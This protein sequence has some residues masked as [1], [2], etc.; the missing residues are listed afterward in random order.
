[1]FGNSPFDSE[2]RKLIT[3]PE[4]AKI[5]FVSDMF[6]EDYVG[7]A[8]LT[9]EALIEASPFE[10]F[11]LHARDVD[12][13]LLEEA[14]NC[15]WIFGNFASLNMELIPTICANIRYS[16]L[17]YDYKFCKYRSPEKHYALENSDCDC[18]DQINGKMISAF[19]YGAKSLWWMSE[20]QMERYHEYFPF[21]SEVNNVVLSSVF[22]DKFFLA[23]KLLKKKNKD[24][25]R[26]GWVV[27]GSASW[28]KGADDAK[29]WCEDNNKDYQ[30]L[31][32]TPY[33]YV[34]ETLAK[35]EGF[36][37]L[38]KG[39]DT[40]P[41]MVIE[42]KLLGCKLHINDFVEHKDEIWFD[43]SDE[44]D[45]EAYLYA[46][47]DRFWGGIKSDMEWCPTLSGY[48]TTLDCD[49]NN[50]PWQASIESMLGFCDEV[51]VMDGGSKDGTW[52]KLLDWS[53]KEDNLH[54]HQVKRDWSH[55]RFAVYDGAN[56]ALARDKCSMD[57]CWQQD[58]D[59]IVHEND[60]QKIKNLMISF[61]GN[62]DIVCL[63][64]VEYWGGE[65]K[66]RMD[67]NPWK[68]RISRN[69]PHITHGIPGALRLKDEDG[70]LYAQPGTDGCDY[71]DSNT[72][73]PIPHA[74]FYNTEAHNC[75][76]KALEGDTVSHTNYSKWFERC[77]DLL[78]TVHHYSWFDLTRKIKTYRDY[79]SQ[80]WQSLYNIEQEDTAENN[81]FFQKP[82]SEVS[83]DDI[84]SLSEALR[85]KTGGWVFHTPIDF[86]KPNPHV[87]LK[88]DHPKYIWSWLG[89]TQESTNEG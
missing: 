41:R 7:G 4:S 42:A 28:I 36:V 32:D 52:E 33:E 35:S 20:K 49:K 67:I 16:I 6:V 18:V 39:G 81:M 11:K 71:I 5:I 74:T 89:R 38:P 63:P 88:S 59:E 68:W 43:T 40:C 21:L 64:V 84:Q 45:T 85:D 66:V 15:H 65:E 75:K 14:Q 51:V 79:W 30:I 82:W 47:R 58:A 37:Y 61:P 62:I 19:F 78:P 13:R 54:A 80:H 87:T 22:D 25:E 9:S 73:D 44:F 56:K 83:D 53:S 10:V 50:Y 57:F 77:V 27:L 29:Q 2:Q 70:S 72:Y 48:I 76:I 12:L 60:F 46:A 55:P 86:S 31:W 1:M 23:L 69:M 3:V 17:E 24:I 8:E 34:L 26:K